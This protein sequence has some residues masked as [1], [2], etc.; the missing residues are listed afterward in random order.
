[1]VE[2]LYQLEEPKVEKDYLYKA[3]GIIPLVLL[4]ILLELKLLESLA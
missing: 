1:M 3:F 2:K 4:S